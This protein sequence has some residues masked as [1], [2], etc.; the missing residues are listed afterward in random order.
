MAICVRPCGTKRLRSPE[1]GTRLAQG[2]NPGWVQVRPWPRVE[3]RGYSR[4]SLRDEEAPEPVGRHKVS[5]GC[6]PWVDL[7]KMPRGHRQIR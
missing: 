3:T 5:P 1:G 7:Q 2:V 6:K 4:P